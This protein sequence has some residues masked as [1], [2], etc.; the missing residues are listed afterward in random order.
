MSS[1]DL[2]GTPRQA[3]ENAMRL[4]REGDADLAREQLLAILQTDPSEVNALRLLGVLEAGRG[5][6]DAAVRRLER[7]VRE[8]PGFLD[9]AL[10]LAHLYQRTGRRVDAESVLGAFCRREPRASIAWQRYADVLFDNG[11][12]EEARQAQRRS[13]ETDRFHADMRRAIEALGAGRPQDAE[14]IYRDVLKKDPRRSTATCRTT[15]RASSSAP[16]RSLRT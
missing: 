13:I 10:D 1:P 11:K 6:L 16:W 12:P 3:F 14:T 8:A 5:E 9:A 4:L 7:A 2:K 15:R